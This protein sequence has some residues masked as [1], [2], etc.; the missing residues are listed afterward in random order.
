[1]SYSIYASPRIHK[2]LIDDDENI[3][4][5]RVARL[6]KMNGIQSKMA[7]KFVITTK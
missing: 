4:R 3:S 7:K 2:N 1:V 5:Q 6:M